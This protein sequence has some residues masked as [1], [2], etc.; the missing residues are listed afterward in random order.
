MK[1]R[2]GGVRGA[3]VEMNE[4]C[5]PRL[6][7]KSR[8]NLPELGVLTIRNDFFLFFISFWLLIGCW[9]RTA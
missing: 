7:V 1:V 8:L 4:L 9:I 3:L 2:V 5:G 6:P